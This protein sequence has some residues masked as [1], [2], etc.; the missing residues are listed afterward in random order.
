MYFFRQGAMIIVL[1]AGGTKASRQ[2]DVLLAK[3]LTK[4]WRSDYA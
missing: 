4:Q 3:R 2:R 1:L